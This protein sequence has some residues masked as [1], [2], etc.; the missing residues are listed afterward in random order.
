MVAFAHNRP[1]SCVSLRARP[2]R[3]GKPHTPWGYLQLSGQRYYNPELGRWPSRDPIGEAGGV[4]IYGFVRNSAII[5]FD[6]LGLVPCDCCDRDMMS[7]IR[8]D[9]NLRDEIL[10][11]TEAH[12]GGDLS[13]PKCLSDMRCSICGSPRTCRLGAGGCFSEERREII[14]CCGDTHN[15]SG[16]DDVSEAVY[17]EL[18][19]AAEAC[20][21]PLPTDCRGDI[22]LEVRARFC[23]G[24]SEAQARSL[25]GNS[26]VDR[27]PCANV[28]RETMQ[29]YA[30]A[31]QLN[32][33][34]CSIPHPSFPSVP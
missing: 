18:Q 8:A 27:T 26:A 25:D 24:E 21:G 2:H 30:T 17:H 9:S 31:C 1:R 13:N 14:I 5:R 22:C 28:S 3:S 23:S 6:I 15:N 4:N 12:V 19:H 33:N 11:L 20:R 16:S 34:I 10:R 32:V 29:G 7:A